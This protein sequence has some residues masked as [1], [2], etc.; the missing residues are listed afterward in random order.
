MQEELCSVQAN[1]ADPAKMVLNGIINIAQA[2]APLAALAASAAKPIED[3]EAKI[4]KLIDQV[5]RLNPLFVYDSIA[6]IRQ[7][8]VSIRR[9]RPWKV[10]AR[11]ATMPRRLL[12]LR[13]PSASS[14]SK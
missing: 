1:I 8:Q 5:L 6:A 14:L 11:S 9:K 2:T 13:K 10:Q 3:L 7:M 12:M 4:Q